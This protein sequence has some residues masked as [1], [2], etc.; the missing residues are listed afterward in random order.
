MSG[1]IIW[2][3]L[4]KLKYSPK[5]K[6]VYSKYIIFISHQKHIHDLLKYTGKLACKP[7]ST[8]V[9]PT[10]KLE[11]AKE[12]SPVNKDIYQTLVEKLIYLSHMK[13]DIEYA[14]SVI[15]LFIKN[16]KEIHL[17]TDY[18]HYSPKKGNHWKNYG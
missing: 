10:H 3:Q 17:Q 9:H 14:I 15:S 7:T 18:K 6:I 4:S 13:L 11:I 5:I 2:I 16:L 8:F 1:K 12:D